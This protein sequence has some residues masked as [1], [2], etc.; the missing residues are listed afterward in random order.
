MPRENPVRKEYFCEGNGQT[1]RGKAV[2]PA[3]KL[4]T[5]IKAHEAYCIKAN[6]GGKSYKKPGSIKK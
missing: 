6:D 3:K 5:R 2:K 1:Y 4:N